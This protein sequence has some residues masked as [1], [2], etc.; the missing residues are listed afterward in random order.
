M[1][2]QREQRGAGLGLGA[3]LGTRGRFSSQGSRRRRGGLVGEME[4]LAGRDEG[5]RG[6]ADDDES[7]KSGAKAEI[8]DVL[9]GEVW[10]ARGSRTWR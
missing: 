1:V 6:S 8:C 2:L 10:L 5:E 7:S 3:R 9:V 4:G